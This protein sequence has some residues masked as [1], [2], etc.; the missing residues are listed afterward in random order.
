[1][2][3]CLLDIFPILE[4]MMIQLGCV[5]LLLLFFLSPSEMVADKGPGEP[6]HENCPQLGS[7]NVHFQMIW[8]L[9]HLRSSGAVRFGQEA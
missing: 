9:Q 8:V 4:N 6:F 7:V 1:M 5:Q 2:R 3:L